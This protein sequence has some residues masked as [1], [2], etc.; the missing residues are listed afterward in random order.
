[1]S[2]AAPAPKHN[3][4]QPVPRLDARLKVHGLQDDDIVIRENVEVPFRQ[5][6]RA[7][8]G[9]V[10]AGNRLHQHGDGKTALVGSQ[11]VPGAVR[12]AIIDRNQ[13]P[14]ARRRM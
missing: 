13:L 3:M 9:S 4:G 12:A 7:I 1:M 14:P 8:E 11:Y 10:L 5:L 6:Q 2:S